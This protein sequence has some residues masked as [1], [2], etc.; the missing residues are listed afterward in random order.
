M[1]PPRLGPGTTVILSTDASGGEIFRR[2]LDRAGHT[3]QKAESQ[4][5]AEEVLEWSNPDLLLVDLSVP[6]ASAYEWLGRIGLRYP[7]LAILVV[8]DD[9]ALAS[10]VT[11]M[12]S[13]AYDYLVKPVDEVRLITAAKNAL[14]FHRLSTR[15][16]SL[17][18]EAK[19]EGFA[20]IVGRSRPMKRLYEQLDRIA[21]SDVTVLIHGESGAGKELVAR[22][23]HEHSSRQN[24]PFVAVNCAAIPETL[25]ESEL[26]GHEKGAFTGASDRRVGRFEQ[27]DGGTLFFD[28]VGELSP[29]L[30][31]KL[32]RVL[33]ERRFTR[34]G[35][36]SELDVDVRVLC[37]THRNLRDEVAAGRFRDDLYYRL[38]VVELDVPPLR[39]RE[40]DIPLLAQTFLDAY[41]ESRDAAWEHRSLDIPVLQ[42]FSYYPWPGNVRELQN[43]PSRH[44][45]IRGHPRHARPGRR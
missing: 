10:A 38:A 31:A 44:S 41:D 2:W 18:R 36:G 22:A 9:S 39:D 29:G 20:G 15:V 19:G 11:A 28:E 7:R 21:A 16:T 1:K 26:F 33:Q 23:I 12:Q 4:S 14:A 8:T 17:E 13:G 27:A 42:T 37:A 34:V 32:L 35:G 43:A 3:V 45:G 30:Q 40:G 5:A 6:G 25:Q 24:A